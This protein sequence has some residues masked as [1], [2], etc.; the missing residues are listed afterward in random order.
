MGPWTY[1]VLPKLYKEILARPFK[2]AVEYQ[3]VVETR[4]WFER[5]VP[6]GQDGLYSWQRDED[7]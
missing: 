7:D 2:S 1:F 5:L 4:E 6:R 3:R